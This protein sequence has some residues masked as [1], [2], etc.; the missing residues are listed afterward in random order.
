MSYQHAYIE[1]NRSGAIRAEKKETAAGSF[2]TQFFI[3]KE[4][5]HLGWDCFNKEKISIGSS[6]KADLVL[7]GSEIFDIHAI[8]Y[9]KG[10]QVV[11]SNQAKNGGVLVNNQ[12]VETAILGRF[13]YLDIGPYTIKIKLL[14]SNSQL[15]SGLDLPAAEKSNEQPKREAETIIP[16]KPNHE[17]EY[18]ES[19]DSINQN[20]QFGEKS[21]PEKVL[22]QVVEQDLDATVEMPENTL[23]NSRSEEQFNIEN[24]KRPA[25]TIEKI[26]ETN[27][28]DRKEKKTRK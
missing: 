27:E 2:I 19:D 22:A 28:F 21:V 4:E 6:G 9:L 7:E 1:K 12:A 3:F 25:N 18:I 14:D 16:E 5:V 10:N 24:D 11:V 26:G 8:V 13:D 15:S 23:K 17:P 20:E